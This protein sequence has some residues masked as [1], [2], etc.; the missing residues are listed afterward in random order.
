[1]LTLEAYERLMSATRSYPRAGPQAASD[2]PSASVT[3]VIFED[4]RRFADQ[5]QEKCLGFERNVRPKRA[6]ADALG[7]RYTPL[8]PDGTN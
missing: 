4:E 1:M 7:R 2:L 3:S 6:V 5:I 8:I